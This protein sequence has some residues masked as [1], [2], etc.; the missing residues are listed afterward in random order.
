MR[1]IF[2]SLLIVFGIT[3]CSLWIEPDP[4]LL[5]TDS[6]LTAT[7]TATVPPPLALGLQFEE[8]ALP[9]PYATQTP[10]PLIDPN[11]FPE[12]YPWFDVPDWHWFPFTLP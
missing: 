12:P 3:A 4:P 7:P 8:T 1:Q 5:V 9:S 2:A 10:L 11:V 6:D